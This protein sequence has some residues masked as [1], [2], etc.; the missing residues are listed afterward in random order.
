ML[1][2]LGALI[3]VLVIARETR[4]THEYNFSPNETS[5]EVAKYRE[6][7]VLPW[8]GYEGRGFLLTLHLKN[9]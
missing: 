6:A 9:Q 1:V 4:E 2:G 7:K 5:K 3:S 8:K